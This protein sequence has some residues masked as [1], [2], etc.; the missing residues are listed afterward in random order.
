M[1]SI[2]IFIQKK[3]NQ[4]EFTILISRKLSIHYLSLVCRWKIYKKIY[5]IIYIYIKYSKIYKITCKKT[6]KIQKISKIYYTFII[7]KK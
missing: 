5:Y 3:K 7:L 6:E 2:S 4:I 1:T